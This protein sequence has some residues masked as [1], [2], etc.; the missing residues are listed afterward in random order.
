MGCSPQGPEG[1]GSL[2]PSEKVSQLLCLFLED[3]CSDVPC[4]LGRQIVNALSS[5]LGT[6]TSDQQSWYG[7]PWHTNASQE[8]GGEVA[9]RQSP[10]AHYAHFTFKK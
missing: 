8:G 3:A 2:H 5:L 7:R 9:D 6:P 10:F 4:L 1:S